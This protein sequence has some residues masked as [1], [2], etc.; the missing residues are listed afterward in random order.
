MAPNGGVT[1]I[2]VT[3]QQKIPVASRPPIGAAAST[4]SCP[5]GNCGGG[6]V[7]SVAVKKKNPPKQRV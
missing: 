6:Q 1:C 3:Y 2:V 4:I 5:V 7:G